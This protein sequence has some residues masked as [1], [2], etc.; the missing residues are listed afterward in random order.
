MELLGDLR[1][2]WTFPSEGALERVPDLFSH[3]GAGIP[4]L[5]LS[6]Q[7]ST[8]RLQQLFILGD[9]WPVK[10]A[11]TKHKCIATRFEPYPAAEVQFQQLAILDRSSQFQA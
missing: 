9:E 1:E 5:K 2:R 8:N 7:L 11:V 3:I 6:F 10:V 4:L